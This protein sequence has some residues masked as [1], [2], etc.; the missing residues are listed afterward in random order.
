ME[1]TLNLLDAEPVLLT[2]NRAVPQAFDLP[3]HDLPGIQLGDASDRTT[4]NFKHQSLVAMHPASSFELSRNFLPE[5]YTAEET[6]SNLRLF[7]Y[8]AYEI[9]C[10]ARSRTNFYRIFYRS[11]PRQ[12]HRLTLEI[13]ITRGSKYW[14]YTKV[15]S[16]TRA[17]GAVRRECLPHSLQTN[18]ESFISNIEKL[19]DDTHITLYLSDETES[20]NHVTDSVMQVVPLPS[21]ATSTAEEML[22]LLDDL[23]CPRYCETE[24]VHIAMIRGPNIFAAYVGGRLLYEV[25]FT[26]FLPSD[27][28]LYTIQLLHC[29]RD[30]TG[31]ARLAGIVLNP[32]G[33]HPKSYLKGLPG[34][35]FMI[36]IMSKELKEGRVLP[37]ERREKWAK[38]I[39]EAVSQIHSKG[40]VAGTLGHV[41]DLPIAIDV[42]DQAMLWNF[43][44]KLWTAKNS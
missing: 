20:I 37:W 7:A 13:T 28:S 11:G 35:G 34:R 1:P 42:S 8:S 26:S 10:S 22:S 21:Q 17:D 4:R 43:H 40:F 3:S 5:I 19:E 23:G 44:N 33:K 15:S 25:K 31:V 39:I 41:N 30:T 16:S 2:S 9:D 29:L 38:E 36:D 6:F 18:I 12:Y 14:E 24:V 27:R 32:K